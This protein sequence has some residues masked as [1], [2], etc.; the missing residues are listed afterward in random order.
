MQRLSK[1]GLE[2]KFTYT[3]EPTNSAVSLFFGDEPTD[4]PA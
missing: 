4:V 2:T 3:S 1:A